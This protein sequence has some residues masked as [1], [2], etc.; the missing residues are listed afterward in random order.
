M[1]QKRLLKIIFLKI[2][3]NKRDMNKFISI[4]SVYKTKKSLLLSEFIN[5][6][7]KGLNRQYYINNAFN[8]LSVCFSIDK[9]FKQNKS[10]KINYLK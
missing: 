9:S 4:R 6:V 8:A 2:F 7:R 3:F 1:E 10:I 5:S